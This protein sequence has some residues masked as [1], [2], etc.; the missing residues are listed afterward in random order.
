VV[1][2]HEPVLDDYWF[3]GWLV[4]GRDGQEYRAEQRD[5]C[6]ARHQQRQRHG[7]LGAGAALVRRKDALPSLRGAGPHHTDP[8]PLPPGMIRSPAAASRARLRRR[9]AGAARPCDPAAR[10]Q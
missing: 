7:R 3:E 2:E 10:S 4:S 8:C 5:R 6:R 9:S 1:A